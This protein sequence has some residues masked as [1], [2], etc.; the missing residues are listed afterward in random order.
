M[1]PVSSFFSQH[2]AAFAKAQPGGTYVLASN[3]RDP[4]GWLSVHGSRTATM[5]P[6]V[7]TYR[8][9]A[10]IAHSRPVQQG[11]NVTSTPVAAGPYAASYSQ[12]E[13]RPTFVKVALRRAVYSAVA[14]IVAAS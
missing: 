13:T 3:C 5:W 11:S 8:A 1:G 12:A 10:S 14:R 7:A 4:E 2:P 9:E 6:K